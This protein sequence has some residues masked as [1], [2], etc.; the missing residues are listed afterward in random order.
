MQPRIQ[1]ARAVSPIESEGVVHRA[2]MKRLTNTFNENNEG[3][4]YL[5]RDDQKCEGE[6]AATSRVGG[7]RDEETH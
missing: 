1:V 5:K 4:T 3:R 2:E 7:G 6:K